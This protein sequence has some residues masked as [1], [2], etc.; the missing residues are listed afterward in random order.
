ML[1]RRALL[2]GLSRGLASVAMLGPLALRRP[3]EVEEEETAWAV[4]IRAD[5][6]QVTGPWT[7]EDFRED[8]VVRALTVELLDEV[9]DRACEIGRNQER[10][11]AAAARHGR[12]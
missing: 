12:L 2:G 7:L 3:L 11:L 4:L 5:N 10:Y 9:F 6:G 8:R 1:S